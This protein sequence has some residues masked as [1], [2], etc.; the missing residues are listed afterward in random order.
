MTTPTSQSRITLKTTSSSLMII[1]CHTHFWVMSYTCYWR[2]CCDCEMQ[3]SNK[4]AVPLLDDEFKCKVCWI[5]S[6]VHLHP[7]H[8]LLM[9][10]V[11]NCSMQ[12]LSQ[13]DARVAILIFKFPGHFSTRTQM[14]LQLRRANYNHFTLYTILN[15]YKLW[16]CVYRFIPKH[17]YSININTVA[18]RFLY[19]RGKVL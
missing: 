19:F 10:Y 14:S 6:H 8:F 11:K 3:N 5:V 2:T 4:S 13:S 16:K 15:D 18:W 17:K 12:C 9:K 1:V 7:Y